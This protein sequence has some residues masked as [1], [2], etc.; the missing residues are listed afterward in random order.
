MPTCTASKSQATMKVFGRYISTCHWIVIIVVLWCDVKCTDDLWTFFWFGISWYTQPGIIPLPTTNL[1]SSKT[2]SEAQAYVQCT[3][4]CSVSVTPSCLSPT[5]NMSLRST[6]SCCP[7]WTRVS[8]TYTETRWR[9]VYSSAFPTLGWVKHVKYQL[10][11][12]GPY[13]I[14]TMQ[15]KPSHTQY[16]VQMVLILVEII[17]MKKV[18]SL[19][20]CIL[21]EFLCVD[22]GCSYC[23][24]LPLFLAMWLSDSQ[25]SSRAV[26]DGDPHH[27]ES[28]WEVSHWC[29]FDEEL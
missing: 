19:V 28:F 1:C 25:S 13:I 8:S 22:H 12:H 18:K 6:N 10:G 24:L 20:G 11:T 3:S 21:S 27:S 9:V 17:I 16:I 5:C 4:S 23:L 29:L 2:Q 15:P 26:F 14:L 7:L